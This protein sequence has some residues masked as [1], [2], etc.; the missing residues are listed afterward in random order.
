MKIKVRMDCGRKRMAVAIL[1]V[2]AFLFPVGAMGDDVPDGSEVESLPGDTV[3]VVNEND[4]ISRKRNFF[5]KIGDYFS[6]SDHF[7][8]DKKIDFGII[9]GPH[10]NSTT[11]LG[12]GVVASG[13][14]RLDKSDPSL[15]LSNLS[16]FGDVTTSGFLMIGLK[17]SNVLPKEKYRFDYSIYVY[18]FPSKFWGIGYDNGNIDDNESAYSRFKFEVKPRFLFRLA[19]NTYLGPLV[20]VQYVHTYDFDAKGAELLGE[21]PEYDFTTIGGGLSFTYDSRDVMFNA[22]KGWFVQLDQLFNPSFFGNKHEYYSTDLTV[23]TYHKA[24][25]GAVI[26]GEFHSLM[27]FKDVPWPMLA[28]VGSP[29][30]M[31]GYFEGRYRDKNIVEAQI[32]L[33]Q[34]IWHRNGAVLWFGAANVFPEFDAMRLRK[35]LLNGGVGYRWAFK[36]G[37][38]VRLD[39][40]F[41]K[42][43]MGFTFNINE[44]F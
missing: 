33:R 20:D 5:Q 15:P 43:G 2:N 6:K 30:R 14:Y 36:Q 8:P 18:T 34:H 12:L 28:N 27:N 41:T 7:N 31:R 32:E 38:N 42:N 3:S 4:T 25:K 13:L 16:L 22:T 40:G 37:V 23:S 26:A 9:G 21:T 19:K 10:Y 24:W 35:T 39:L 44:A 11:G 17:G 1:L 29:N